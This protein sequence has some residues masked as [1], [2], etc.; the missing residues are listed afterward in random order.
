MNPAKL[1]RLTEPEARAMIERIR[2]PE[3]AICPHCQSQNVAKLGGQAGEKGQYKCRECRKKFTVRVGTIF[4]DSHIPL[5][6]WVYAFTRMC[7]SK[8]GIS[9]HQLHRELE[10][11][12][13]SAWFMCHRIRHAMQDFRSAMLGGED[14]GPVEVD[15]TYVGGKPRNRHESKRGRGTKKTPVLALVERDGKARAAAVQGVKP[16]DLRDFMESNIHKAT[17]LMTDEASFY[18]VLNKNF[19]S[20]ETVNHS[21]GEYVRGDASTNEVESFFALIKRQHYG[22]HHHYSR[23]HI[24]RYVNENVF[25]WNTRKV[26]CVTRTKNAI[27]QAEGKRLTYRR[28]H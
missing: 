13:K 15:E 24:G 16:E 1:C 28:T 2:W 19:L 26:D 17:R 12:Y 18:K 20:H 23:Q 8:K 11:T 3:G 21:K 14:G 25:K 27:A 4:E 10:I 5:H 9:A 7:A 22:T 6:D